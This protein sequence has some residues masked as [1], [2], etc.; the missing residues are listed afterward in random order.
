MDKS[1][2]FSVFRKSKIMSSPNAPDEVPADVLALRQQLSYLRQQKQDQARDIAML[3][4]LMDTLLTVEG[5]RRESSRSR[6][7]VQSS[8]QPPH[9]HHHHR[10]R[11][12]ETLNVQ[13]HEVLDENT[14]LQREVTLATQNLRTKDE[15]LE[16]AASRLVEVEE[17]LA[18]V[19]E[20]KQ[21][22]IILGK[23]A[24]RSSPEQDSSSSSSWQLLQLA[25]TPSESLSSSPRSTSTTT[26][27]AD[28]VSRLL[29]QLPP[30][31]KER[32]RFLLS[33]KRRQ[34]DVLM[35]GFVLEDVTP[36][37]L[38]GIQ[39]HVLPLLTN[40]EGVKA[41]KVR[42]RTRPR[43]STDLQIHCEFRPESA[44]SSLEC[45]STPPILRTTITNSSGALVQQ[46]HHRRHHH[47]VKTSPN[48]TT[49]PSS[50][51]SPAPKQ[52]LSPQHFASPAS[53]DVFPSLLTS[54]SSSSSSL[55]HYPRTPG[56][57]A[58]RGSNHVDLG[59]DH[60]F[61][62]Y[63][64]LDLD[65]TTNLCPV[66]H[67]LRE[68][69]A[70]KASY[71][72]RPTL[73]TKL[74]NTRDSWGAKT[75]QLFFGSASSSSSSGSSQGSFS[76]HKK[77]IHVGTTC[78]GCR[79]SPL[80]GKRWTCQVC[81]ELELCD[82]CYSQGVHGLDSSEDIFVR[83]EQI[84]IDKCPK[85]RSEQELLE[86]LRYDICKLNLKK[87]TFCLTW[88]ADI[89]AGK[90]TKEL[91]ARALE[92]PRIRPEVRSKFVPLLTRI[93]SNRDDIDITTEWKTEAPD[94]RSG[95]SRRGGPA[96]ERETLRIWVRDGF[97]STSPFAAK[98]ASASGTSSSSYKAN[99]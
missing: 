60:H 8:S 50:S 27:T 93:V 83:V 6:S 13:L 90:S 23:L 46:D 59:H 64:P 68:L 79:K 85:L 94:V 48:G 31:S 86:L 37:V 7:G 76:H 9:H 87:F 30:T 12:L 65:L 25:K 81:P 38:Q 18:R 73:E 95:S 17:T 54:S 11:N 47:H 70:T 34:Q 51:S 2:P 16:R 33:G 88:I 49:S 5:V 1:K 4:H 36:E 26:T 24:R 74:D 20:E 71:V 75:K 44:P 72:S 45:S 92:I 14:R 84:V 52:K 55:S 39:C 35:E 62:G 98:E 53:P 69:H 43:T 32:L 78:S 42:S 40:Q 29:S 3:R 67:T 61:V 91:K 97:K 66:L 19:L 82:S 28:D 56:L 77:F 57:H 41:V 63:E 80:V 21:Q 58:R 96:S 89:V 22:N 15:R 10:H 99:A